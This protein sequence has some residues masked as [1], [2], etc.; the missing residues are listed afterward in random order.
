MPA[1]NRWGEAVV[2]KKFIKEFINNGGNLTQATLAT[3][4]M[5]YDSAS[6]RGVQLMK[7]Q[8]YQEELM[9][10]LT[11]LE[12]D[13]QYIISRRKEFIEA[14]IKQLREGRDL[15]DVKVSPKD[16]DSHLSALE[17]LWDKA[18]KSTQ[19]NTNQHIH[20]HLKNKTTTEV[21]QTRNELQDWF[22]N[23]LED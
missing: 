13:I 12:V 8:D 20:L 22:Q 19:T 3:Y 5:K 21:L 10:A 15:G 11:S 4:P 14:G 2:R 17:K 23:V 18:S 16:V 1:K 9:K 6:V 7:R